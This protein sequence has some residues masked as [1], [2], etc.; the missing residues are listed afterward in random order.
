MTAGAGDS[1]VQPISTAS[2]R[3]FRDKPRHLR[4]D[5]VL[6]FE[7]RPSSFMDVLASNNVVSDSDSPALAV[8]ALSS[9][10]RDDEAVHTRADDHY[11]GVLF[12]RGYEPRP[13]EFESRGRAGLS[14]DHPTKCSPC[15]LTANPA[16]LYS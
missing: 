8:A 2:L 7:H 14:S 9:R 1:G 5:L 3:A 16:I 6:H 13:R 4:A 12:I 10:Y 11:R 15:T